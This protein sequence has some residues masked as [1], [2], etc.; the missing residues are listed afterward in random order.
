MKERL[1]IVGIGSLAPEVYN[2]VKRYDLYDVIAFAVD[3]KYL[4]ESYYGLPVYPFEEL[5]KYIDKNTTKFFVAISWYNKF[6][7][8][9]REKYEELK[10]Y[11]FHF[12]NLIS[13]NAIVSTQNIGEGNW[14]HDGAIV[15]YGVQIGDNNTILLNTLI[16]HYST[17]GN[18]NVLVGKVTIGGDTNIGDGCYF[19][20]SAV[21]FNKLE[22][23]NSCMV[24]GAATV[25]HNLK[26]YT[27]VTSQDSIYRQ[28]TLKLIELIMS[29]NGAKYINEFNN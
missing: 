18:H 24:G 25:R 20:M 5:E 19:G 6:N 22:I 23:G 28:G 4:V 12:A 27:I 8:Y 2:F 9:K 10:T 17:L 7:K 3:K 15:D 26:D 11:G 29:P 14:I 21:V 13:P 1:V 16:G